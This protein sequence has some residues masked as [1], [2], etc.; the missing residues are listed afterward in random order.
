[1]ILPDS[2]DKDTEVIELALE[3]RVKGLRILV[4]IDST[5]PGLKDDL[6]RTERLRRRFLAL[7]CKDF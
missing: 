5:S 7:N 3:T 4:Q 6:E 1:M 2:P